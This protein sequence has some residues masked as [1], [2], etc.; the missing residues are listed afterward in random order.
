MKSVNLLIYEQRQPG[1]NASVYKV[2]WFYDYNFSAILE[3][4]LQLRSETE[5]FRRNSKVF[6]EL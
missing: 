5:T 1:W 6:E 3:Y 4:L 2:C